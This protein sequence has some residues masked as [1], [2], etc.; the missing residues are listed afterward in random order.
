MRVELDEDATRAAEKACG[1][2]GMSVNAYINWLAVSVAHVEI[3]EAASITIKPEPPVNAPRRVIRKRQAWS[4][5][6]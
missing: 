1:Q 2:L 6:F 4:T 5:N 3:V